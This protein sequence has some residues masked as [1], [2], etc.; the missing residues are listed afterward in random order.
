MS[1]PKLQLHFV[2]VTRRAGFF[3]MAVK[4]GLV[5]ARFDR[6]GVTK[7]IMSV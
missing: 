7:L 4:K 5:T 2:R 6:L 3:V 1:Q